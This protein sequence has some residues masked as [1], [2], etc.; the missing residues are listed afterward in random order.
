MKILVAEDNPL[1]LELA[2]DLLELEGHQVVTAED[3]DQAV[4]LAQEHRPDLVLMDL[5]MPRLDGLD[6]TRRLKQDPRTSGIPVIAL[7]ASAMPAE[8]DEALA[9][10]CLGHLVKPIDTTRFVQ[11][12]TAMVEGLGQEGR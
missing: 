12:V 3:G 10:G 6:A 2:R 9:A 7:T 5:H 11:Q 1:N 8:R 4:R